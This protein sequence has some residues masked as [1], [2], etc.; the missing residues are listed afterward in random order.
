MDEEDSHIISID[1][2]YV[3]SMEN[4][5]KDL[6]NTGRQWATEAYQYFINSGLNQVTIADMRAEIDSLKAQVVLLED[7]Q[8]NNMV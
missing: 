2:R 4:H 1:G 6:Q 5:I 8:F 3:Q 7:R